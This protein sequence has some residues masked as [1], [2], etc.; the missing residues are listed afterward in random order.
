MVLFDCGATEAHAVAERVRRRVADR[1]IET[2]ATPVPV[3]LSIGLA[4][5][6]G[7]TGEALVAV[8]DRALY[9]AKAAGRNVSRAG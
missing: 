3:T 8:A 5:A 9:A 1:P 2:R 7:G 6:T 4:T